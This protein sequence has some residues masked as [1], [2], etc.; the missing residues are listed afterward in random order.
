M[1]SPCRG[2]RSHIEEPGFRVTSSS[3]QPGN[4]HTGSDDILDKI[5]RLQWCGIYTR[6]SRGP[7]DEYSSCQAQFEACLAFVTSRFDDGWVFNG[8]RYDDEA[9]SSETLDRPGLQKLLEHIREGKVQRVVIH[10][11][12]RLSRRLV[13]CTKFLQELHDLHIP[14]TIVKQP[15]LGVTAEHNLLLNLMASF[16]E[17]EQQMT[18]ERLADARAALKRHGR[19]I[20]GVVPY[21]YKADPVTRQL[22]VVKAEA[23]R[24][25]Q[26][27]ELAADGKTPAEIAAI[28]NHHGWRTKQRRSRKG[29]VTGGGRWTARQVLA[30]LSNPVYAGLIRDG[31]QIRP[32]AH[33]PIVDRELFDQVQQIIASRRTSSRDRRTSPAGWPLRGIRHCGQC[34]RPMSPSISGHKNFRYR[35]YRCRSDAGGQPACK[36]VSIPA[37]EIETFVARALG[38]AEFHQSQGD[39]DG[40]P[41]ERFAEFLR[42]WPQLP[43]HV[44]SQALPRL[45]REVVYDPKHSTITVNLDADAI[46]EFP[47]APPTTP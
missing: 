11:L 13:D 16:A 38:D 34:G 7:K 29:R 26:M 42:I 15:E 25:R 8:R 12:D 45:V 36:G 2:P 24:V 41:D 3:A 43:H 47:Q 46:A 21:G 6:Q 35:Y 40:P 4:A 19:R 44:Q 23:R 14:L 32:G 33:K 10:R 17:F 28:A 39:A 18:R 20:A 27:F 30:I 5:R 31:D 1:D 37:Q 22:V 9:E